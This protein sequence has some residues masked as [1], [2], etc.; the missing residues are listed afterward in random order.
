MSRF[1]QLF[2]DADRDAHLFVRDG[3]IRLGQRIQVPHTQDW[4]EAIRHNDAAFVLLGIPEDIGVRANLGIGGTQ[5]AWPATLKAL[6]NIQS[7]SGFTGSEMLLLGHF[8]F[9]EFL[10]HSQTATLEE[11]RALTAQIDE[12]VAPLMEQI[13]AAG[14]IPIVVGGG[15]NNAYPILKAC[16]TALNR[17]IHCINLDAHSDYRRIEGRH[18]GNGFRY[19]RQN[20]FLDRYAVI[21]LHESYN[22][23]NIVSEFAETEYLQ[24]SFF[25]D[26]FI[27]QNISFREALLQATEHVSGGPVGIELDMDAIEGVLSSAQTPSGINSRDARRYIHFCTQT[28]PVC[29]LHL[30]EAAVSLDGREAMAPTNGKL[31]AYLIADFV[32]GMIARKARNSAV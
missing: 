27:R 22:A 23:A 9:R 18:S 11:L 21:G 24:A 31:L 10:D 16:S 1:F 19:A 7:T 28:V 14:K 4:Q 6:L 17:S 30:P 13:V 26:I 20:G 32:R 2:T 8:S 29:Y 3:E 25:E 5:T 15:H 12:E